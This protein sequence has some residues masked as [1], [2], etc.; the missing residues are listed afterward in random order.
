MT[1]LLL[2][3]LFAASGLFALATIHHNWRRYGAVAAALRGELRACAEWREVTVTITAI[4]VHPGGAT[5]LRPDFKGR[6][7]PT[8]MPA[9][10]AAA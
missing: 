6:R 3:A 1:A 5:I 8:P 2:S 7:S 10:P 4:K 9:L